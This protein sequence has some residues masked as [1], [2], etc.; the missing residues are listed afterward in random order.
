MKNEMRYVKQH[1][2]WYEYD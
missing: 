2:W 1:S